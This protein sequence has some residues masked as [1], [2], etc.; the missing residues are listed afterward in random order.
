MWA[1]VESASAVPSVFSS[2]ELYKC[3]FLQDALSGY[4]FPLDHLQ[5]TAAF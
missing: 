2:I 1:G 4:C 5:S 3:R